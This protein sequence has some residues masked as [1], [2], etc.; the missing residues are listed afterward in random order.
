MPVIGFLNGASAALRAHVRAFPRA[1]AKPAM[2]RARTW[3]SNIAGRRAK[4]IGCRHGG[5]FRPS[6]GD[7]D[8]RD[9]DSGGARSKGGDHDDPD[10]VHD[11]ATRSSSARRQP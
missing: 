11:G 5:R 3:R 4:T 6:P 8:C 9:Q 2:S 7:R 10:R 1:W